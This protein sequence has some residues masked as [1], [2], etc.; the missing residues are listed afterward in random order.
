MGSKQNG[1]QRWCSHVGLRLSAGMLA[2]TVLLGPTSPVLARD[3]VATSLRLSGDAKRTQFVAEL[4]DSVKFQVFALANPYRVIVDLPKLSFQVPAGTGQEVRGLVSAF[5]YGLFAPGKARIVLDA[6]GPVRIDVAKLVPAN[7]G[8]ARRLVLELVQTDQ[9]SFSEERAARSNASN[10]QSASLRGS[11]VAKPKKGTQNKTVII[12]DPGHGGI[13]S[14]AVNRKGVREKEIALKFAQTLREELGRRKNYHI[15]MTRNTDVFVPLG[16]RV[17]FARANAG[18]LF[19]S[20]HTDSLPKRYAKRVRGA[21]VY[22]LSENGSDAVARALAAKEN[23][24]DVIAGVELEEKEDVLAGILIDLAQ[25][26]TKIRSTSFARSI[27]SQIKRATKLNK[28]PLRSAAFQVLKAPDI[29]SVLLELG[30]L[31]NGGD[32]RLLRSKKWR[33]KVAKRVAVAVDKY[34]E[35]RLAGF[36][37]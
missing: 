14:G 34:F 4:S 27:L 9:A 35:K 1:L 19:I 26:E 37:F 5:R 12:I 25:R 7:G 32:A 31:S 15:L 11:L 22:T 18:K 33:A 3:V 8:Q 17:E 24:S 29:P 6:K 36:P 23:R 10:G 2:L 30:Y 28:Q 16:K 21:T 20:I 13:D